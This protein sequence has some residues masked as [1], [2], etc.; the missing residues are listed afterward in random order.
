[1]QQMI[2][3]PAEQL[4]NEVKNIVETAISNRTQND[5]SE[6]LLSAAEAC[7]LFQPSISK[8][9]LHR[10]TKEGLIP[11]HRMRGRIYYKQSEVIAA[12]QAITKYSRNKPHQA[13]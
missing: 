13:A 2:I 12:A 6:K 8:V 3:M 4:L 9:T 1:M 5:N 11:V 10:W 7:K